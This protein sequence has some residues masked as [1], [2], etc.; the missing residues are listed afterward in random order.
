[1]KNFNIF[2][3]EL[4]IYPLLICMFYINLFKTH[5]HM[6]IY[7]NCFFC[8][9]SQFFLLVRHQNLLNK[10]LVANWNF[11]DT[12][13]PVHDQDHEVII[14]PPN[15]HWRQFLALH[16]KRFHH[17]RRNKKAIFSEVGNLNVK[18]VINKLIQC[19]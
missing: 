12:T 5:L 1:M 19:Y 2:V 10:K 6:A 9:I 7:N 11:S 4:N 17:T 18:V 15:K 16:I 8:T 13:V 3:L 14:P